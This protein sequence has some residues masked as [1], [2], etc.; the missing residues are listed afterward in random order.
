MKI[1]YFLFAASS[2]SVH[3]LLSLG[4]YRLFLEEVAL[5]LAATKEAL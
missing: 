5:P 2:H 4:V 1:S 3:V